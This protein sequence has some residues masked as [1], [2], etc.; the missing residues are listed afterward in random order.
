L[1]ATICKSCF[2]HGRIKEVNKRG[3]SRPV[4][5]ATT[6]CWNCGHWSLRMQ[7]FHYFIFLTLKHQKKNVLKNVINTVI[8]VMNFVMYF[9]AKRKSEEGHLPIISD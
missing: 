5:L 1:T 2:T 3:F 4:S 7:V 6:A 8:T 9:A